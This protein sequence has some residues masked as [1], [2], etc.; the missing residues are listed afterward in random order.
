VERP[1]LNAKD[2]EIAMESLE[3]CHEGLEIDAQA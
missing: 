1:R 2:N 3:I